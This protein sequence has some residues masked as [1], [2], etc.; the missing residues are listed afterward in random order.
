[1]PRVARLL[2]FLLAIPAA[3][4]AATAYEPPVPAP[5]LVLAAGAAEIFDSDTFACASVN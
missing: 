4:A 5:N 3:G 2:P 1:M